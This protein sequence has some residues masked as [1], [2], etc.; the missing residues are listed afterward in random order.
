[1]SLPTRVLRSEATA[2]VLRCLATCALTAA[3]AV[4]PAT[5]TCC[6]APHV[7]DR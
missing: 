7:D 5:S 6:A 4:R 1:M 2:R 3:R